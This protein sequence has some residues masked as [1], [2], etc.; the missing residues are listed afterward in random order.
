VSERHRRPYESV[1][2]LVGWTPLVRLHKVV[3]GC[4]TPVY[5]KCEFMNPGGSV[6]DRIGLAMIE[7]AERRGVLK[8]GGTI[9]EAT[10]GN[11]GLAL[12]MAAAPKG[13]RCIFTMPDKMSQEKVKLLRAFGAEVVITPTAVPP[14]HPEHYLNRAKRIAHDT[15]GAV[16]ANQ[17][18]NQANPDAHYRTTGPELW[19]QSEGRITHFFAGAGTGGTITGTGRY[20]KEKNPAVK[21]VGVDPE[22][23]VI[24]PFFR[25][26]EMVQG[27]PYKVEGLGNDKI[28]GALDLD[29]V[30]DYVTVSDGESFRMARRLAREEGLFVGGSSGLNTHAAVTYAKELDDPNALLVTTLADWG[31][32]YLSKLYDDDWMRE[33][34]FL[35]R[36]RRRTVDELVGAKEEG[37]PALVSVEPATSVRM[38]LSTI[39]SHGVSQLPVVRDGECVGSLSEDRLMARVIESPALLDRP[40]ESVMDAPYPVVEAHVELEEI[41]PLLTRANAAC[42]VRRN[43]ALT[44]IVTRYDLVRALAAGAGG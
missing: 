11:T 43:G 9:V 23:S 13:Y 7:D 8:Q 31:E 22:G 42:L 1:L 34:G 41:T 15:P 19:E 18:Y 17:F 26:G 28:P 40:V 32:R 16:L 27:H 3:D 14:D 39:S 38:A 30:D 21:I 35:A 12:A 4:R 24:G 33:N 6:K 44:G 5:A 2:D 36:R 29:V 10:S 37:I 25:T 20:L